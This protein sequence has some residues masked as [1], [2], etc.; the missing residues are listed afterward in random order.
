MWGT[1]VKVSSNSADV[2]ARE[3]HLLNSSDSPHGAGTWKNVGAPDTTAPYSTSWNDTRIA[4]GHYDL[5]VTTVDKA[6]HTFTSAVVTVVV[7]KHLAFALGKVRVVPRGTKSYLTETMKPSAKVKISVTLR[8]GGKVVYR[9]RFAMKAGRHTASLLIPTSRLKVGGYTLS[10]RATSADTQSMKRT[11]TFRVLPEA[12]TEAET[13]AHVLGADIMKSEADARST[14]WIGTDLAGYRIESLIDRGGMGDV[15]LA[16]NPMTGNKVALKILAPEFA[17]LEEVQERLI[18]ES[19]IVSRIDHPNILRIY[20]ADFS[21]GALYVAMRH[22][23]GPDLKRVLHQQRRFSFDGILVIMSQLASALDAAHA[24]GLFHGNVK[25]GN[26]LIAPKKGADG[27]DFVYL[28]GFGFTRRLERPARLSGELSGA[29]DYAA[30]ERF[31]GGPIDARS[32][33]YSLGCLLLECLVSRDIPPAVQAVIGKA[34]ATDPDRRY[35]TCA[36]MIAHLGEAILEAAMAPRSEPLLHP[37][38][39]VVAPVVAAMPSPR[40]SP[41]QSPSRSPSRRSRS[42]QQS[43][44]SPW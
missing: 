32:D 31:E 1:K 25:P 13:E 42:Q 15:Y 7:P 20:D 14:Q 24:T 44:R 41:R 36:E 4:T 5:R 22:V 39:P 19:R 34:I 26:V 12:E 21:G 27:S 33:I 2:G 40:Q 17:Y 11:T 29:V 37:V 30:P 43:S 23:E 28:T 10:A 35:A 9:W 16:Q 8:L 38:E 18:R 3:W 6:G